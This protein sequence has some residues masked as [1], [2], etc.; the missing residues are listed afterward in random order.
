MADGIV[1]RAIADPA[2]VLTRG[3]VLI[4]DKPSGPTSHDVVTVVRRA[5]RD[6]KTGH[7]GTLDPAATGVLPIVIGKA[8]RLAQFLA[9]GEKEYLACIR[10][11]SATD[12]YDASGAVTS[13]SDEAPSSVSAGALE[14][15]LS[16]FRG[17][18]LQAPP[19][20]SAKQTGGVRAYSQA[21]K[22]KAVGL[23]EVEVEVRALELMSV[24]GPDLTVRLV[25]SPGFYV[26]SFAHDLGQH[27]GPGGHLLS[28]RRL[29]SGQFGLDEAVTL[30][31]VVTE[32][33]DVSRRM[34][35]IDSLLTHLPEVR[36]TE[37]GCRWMAH[38]RPL[39]A[40]V[41]ASPPGTAGSGLVRL[42]SPAGLLLGLGDPGLDGTLRPTIVLV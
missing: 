38:G 42:L 3:G 13:G 32:G 19:A 4:V 31:V 10:L 23:S 15:A 21:R 8:T 27:L 12:T 41:L 39:A 34:I 17:R 40:E 28:L 37:E 6:A 33:R 1:H 30:D 5:L 7:T 18:Y 14:T 20:Y 24:E 9:A 2:D 36:L 11:G 16:R 22:G 25:T 26:R 29:R 35:G